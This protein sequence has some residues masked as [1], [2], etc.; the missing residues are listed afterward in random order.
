V[1]LQRYAAVLVKCPQFDGGFYLPD[2][3]PEDL[4]MPFG[5]FAQKHDI[6]DAVQTIFS[7]TS[8]FGDILELPAPQ[9]MRTFSLSLLATM[10]NFQ[11]SSV[12]GNILLFQKITA[13]L[14]ASNSLLCPLWLRRHSV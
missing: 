3:V 11:P 9:Q 10:Q 2:T 4:S 5:Q 12:M 1:A 13:E 14:Q 8:A 7:L 6:A